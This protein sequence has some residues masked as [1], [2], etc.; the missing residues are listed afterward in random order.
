M[1]RNSIT[2][3]STPVKAQEEKKSIAKEGG[4][5]LA[6]SVAAPQEAEDRASNADPAFLSGLFQLRTPKRRSRK[7]EHHTD[8]VVGTTG[9]PVSRS[10]T[11][12]DS[13]FIDFV[14]QRF[15]RLHIYSPVRYYDRQGPESLDELEK[16]LR[17]PIIGSYLRY[18]MHSLEQLVSMPFCYLAKTSDP[19][20]LQLAVTYIDNNELSNNIYI[21]HFV[22]DR[23]AISAFTEY[24][25]Q[26]EAHHGFAL[27]SSS[28]DLESLRSVYPTSR[29]ITEEE[30]SSGI[31]PVNDIKLPKH[32]FVLNLF[33]KPSLLGNE[34]EASIA[35]KF[36][37]EAAL[38]ALPYET[39][40]LL[41]NVAI[42]DA[43][44]TYKKIHAVVIRGGFFCPL[45]LD[46]VSEYLQIPKNNMIMGKFRRLVHHLSPFSHSAS[47]QVFPIRSFLSPLL[48]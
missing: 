33:I 40:Q 43:F 44:Y 10:P 26:Y 1:I 47:V 36:S 19:I 24:K 29:R 6:G 23:K 32:G 13:S 48:N 14:Q 35:S 20:S 2:R 15:S 16:L 41:H 8:P 11:G 37:L 3:L 27:D 12:R 46:S 38:P 18:L 31:P 22:D 17:R 9:S 34:G 42:L 4:T 28:P 39:Q 30:Y 25:K 5:T 21:L 45:A 7:E